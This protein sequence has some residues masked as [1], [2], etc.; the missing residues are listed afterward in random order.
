MTTKVLLLLRGVIKNYRL[1]AIASICK[2]N[3]LGYNLWSHFLSLFLLL[4]FDL[5]LFIFLF[6]VDWKRPDVSLDCFE[7]LGNLLL[8][9]CVLANNP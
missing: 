4:F 6:R 1:C 8:V 2:H 9:N 5:F 3:C 7:S